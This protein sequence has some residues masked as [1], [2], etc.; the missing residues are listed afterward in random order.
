MSPSPATGAAA[1]A[2]APAAAGADDLIVFHD[3]SK[4]YGETLGVNHV[5]LSIKPG[6]TS[7]VGPNG[8]GKSTLMGLMTGIVRPT[9]GRVRVLGIEPDDPERMFRKVG[10]CTQHDTFPRGLSGRALLRAFLGLHGHGPDWAAE[11]AELALARV[12]LVEAGARSVAGYSK[13]M[14]QRIR[15]ALAL[16]HD[17]QVLV[18]DEPLNGLDPLARSEMITLFRDIA[19]EGRH[20]ILSS[21]I[22]HEVDLISDQVVL[23]NEGYVVAEGEIHA[24]RGEMKKHPLQI[25]I[26]CDR[27]QALA[28]RAI[29][30]DSVCEVKLAPDRRA[31]LLRT[32]DADAFF[33]L[34]NRIVLDGRFTIESITPADDDVNAVYQYLIQNGRTMS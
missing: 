12:N 26:R 5:S 11:R 9:A 29:A 23:L 21:H 28:A 1:A 27:P 16:A 3:V 31:L 18:L 4:F 7:L 13:G 10:F 19:A 33:L 14:R 15:L 6:I 17:P 25:L 8:A 2:G 22:L 24:V 32:D 34:L 20:V 30:E